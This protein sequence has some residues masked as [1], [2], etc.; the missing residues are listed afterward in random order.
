MSK[1]LNYGS[2]LCYNL[3]NMR[4]RIISALLLSVVLIVGAT[5]LKFDRNN[6]AEAS[7]VSVENKPGQ[8]TD[9]YIPTSEANLSNPVSTTTEER[10]TTTDLVGRQMIIDY[11]NL[12]NA[13][14]VTKESLDNLAEKYVDMVPSLA[15]SPQISPAEIKLV[16]N[17]KNNFISYDEITTK[18]ETER[19]K[20]I[21]NIYASNGVSDILDVKFY[22]L[23]GAVGVAYENAA[24]RFLDIPVPALLAPA[25]TKLI[26]NYL[27]TASGMKSISELDKDSI[28][29]FSG[30][31]ALNKSIGEEKMI[32]NEIIAI[33]LKNGK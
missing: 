3:H 10:L 25:H 28:T 18:I 26:N 17:S 13:G 11:L 12:A 30:A 19:I 1:Q 2:M 7:L 24:K 5:W 21:N 32:V 16:T 27:S 14:S 22:K 20:I 9:T 8:D 4:A 31:I 29:A 6:P 33:L 23:A 15:T